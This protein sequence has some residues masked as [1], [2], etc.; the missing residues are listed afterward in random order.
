M[1]V[2]LKTI[3]DNIIQK[4]EDEITDPINRI[5][6]KFVDHGKG[7]HKAKTPRILV[8]RERDA[9]MPCTGV[10]EIK[11]DF[12]VTFQIRLDVEAS[13]GGLVGVKRY[14]GNELANMLSD[15]IVE[16]MEDCVLTI[17]GIKQATRISV[18]SYEYDNM[19]YYVHL[20][21]VYLVN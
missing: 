21:G 3:E 9:S 14:T 8:T 1:T 7:H 13:V 4:L 17:T 5:I 6:G 20:Y 18:G 11:Q 12:D 15:K 10:G 16:V 19:H 2:S